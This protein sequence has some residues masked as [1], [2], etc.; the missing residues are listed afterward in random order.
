MCPLSLI[1]PIHASNLDTWLPQP[2]Q[3]RIPSTAK[4]N[5]IC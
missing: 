3:K 5:I 4:R 2:K 1:G